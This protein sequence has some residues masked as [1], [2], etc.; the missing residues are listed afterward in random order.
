MAAGSSKS[1]QTATA[2]VL[3]IFGITGDLAKK[4]TL[5]SLYRL[6]RR[7]QLDCRIIGVARNDWTVEHLVEHARKA[8]KATVDDYDE[9]IF[10]RLAARFEYVPGD[11]GEDAT[12]K[13]VA[14][15]VGD[16]ERPVFYLEVPPF[17]FAEVV[18][19]LHA[20]GLTKR[21]RVVI[22]K[23]FGH[24]LAS[25][26]ALNHDLHHV[27]NEDQIFRIDH[28]LGKEPVM[29]ILYLR[30]A[31]T[32]LEPVWNRR[33]VDSVHITMAE[34]FG[35]EDRGRFYDP[36]GTLRDVVQNHLLQL[37]ALVAMEPPSGAYTDEDPVRDKKLDL[38]KSIPS[39]DSAAYVRGQYDGYLDVDGV[40]KDSNTETYAALR[41]EV[42]NW[43][44]SGVPF[45][46]RAGKALA[47]RVTEIRVIFRS[48][49]PL[50]IGGRV[51]PEGDEMIFRIDPDPGSSI[52]VEAKQPGAEQL[53]QVHLD[54]LFTQQL[55]EQP[56]PYE[57]LLGD[58]LAGNRQRFTD[59]DGID[60]TW[61]IVQPLLDEPAE[62]RTYE[63]GTWGPDAANRLVDGHGGWRTP[64]T[65]P[66]SDDP[67]S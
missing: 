34:D 48:P 20:V 16:G 8:V 65:P 46:I 55:G 11:Y 6:E 25:A 37:L 67:P 1:E 42:E 52:I 15:A 51:A 5:G 61:R 31:N 39:A 18:Q 50:G 62:L 2:D 60:Q 54:L 45:F 57:R 47:K 24:D 32:L 9:A 14:E 58:A 22:E 64:W 3:V 28:F 29:D 7:N 59:Q 4:M 12:F 35:V 63:T 43:R 36:V 30:F 53:R 56:T 33:Y 17:L 41:L 27:L 44:W 23:P 10:K 38:F 13:R 21:A 26:D 49:P 40:A 19:R 66:H